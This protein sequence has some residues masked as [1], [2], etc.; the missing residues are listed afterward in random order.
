[1]T[2]NNPKT[3]LTIGETAT[4]TITVT[5]TNATNKEVIWSTS[6]SK[7]ATVDENGNVTAKAVGTATIFVI[8]RDN[9]NISATYTLTVKAKE[10]A[11]PGCVQ[12]N[13]NITNFVTRL[14][15]LCLNRCPDATGLKYWSDA[16]K[17]GRQTAAQVAK[18]FFES[19]EM[20]NLKLSDDE[21][22]KRCYRVMMNREA[23]NSGKAYW[24]DRLAVGMTR[25][26]V[27]KGFVASNEFTKICQDYKVTKGNIDT[28]E[29]RDL[30]YGVTAFIARC[31]KSVL[32]RGYDVNGLN[33]WTGKIMESANKKEEAA[34]AAS[35]G[36]FNSNEFLNKG[37]SDRD[38]IKV[39]YRTFLD[40]EAD[41]RGLNYWLTQMPKGKDVILKGFANSN[42]FNAIM[43]RYGIR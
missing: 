3:S 43:A 1:M 41:A 18:G 35:S 24:M 33:Y 36:F 30:N 6:D 4:N 7:V 21:F 12:G 2:I 8:S 34:N 13:D 31:F 37:L 16:L 22:V 29:N 20:K 42:E 10:E 15:E 40:R 5:P 39:C 11:K 14:Y 25:L 26:S 23:D 27:V 38:F 32:G 9:N 28:V 19:N 17:S